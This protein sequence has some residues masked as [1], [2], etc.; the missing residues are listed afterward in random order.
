MYLA[1]VYTNTVNTPS[2]P[3]QRFEFGQAD[4]MKTC[5]DMNKEAVN[6]KYIGL[7]VLSVVR[8]S[9]AYLQS[10]IRQRLNT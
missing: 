8:H 4:H 2:Y 10:T 3:Q 6:Y 7:S 9:S 1:H 5:T